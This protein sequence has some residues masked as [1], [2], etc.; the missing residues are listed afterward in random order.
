MQQPLTRA[1]I[2]IS[3]CPSPIRPSSYLLHGE[4]STPH[5]TAPTL[6]RPVADR[7][8]HADGNGNA[9]ARKASSAPQR[10]VPTQPQSHT[11]RS[12]PSNAPRLARTS[13]TPRPWPNANASKAR[14]PCTPT[15]TQ[16]H[17]RGMPA[18][19][20]S[21]RALRAALLSVSP[22]PQWCATRP[23]APSP[24][25]RYTAPREAHRTLRCFA[26]VLL[27]ARRCSHART[28]GSVA[29][30]GARHSGTGIGLHAAHHGW[31]I[32]RALEA[33]ASH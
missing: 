21:H 6:R 23:G 33:P 17:A 24:H 20:E 15:A 18:A 26:R 32:S 31:R 9:N 4:S 13:R 28:Q 2:S 29:A 14:R 10:P 11:A 8:P 7:R 1:H 5:H 27:L 12:Q 22:A 3:I 19:A 25:V 30:T 16:P